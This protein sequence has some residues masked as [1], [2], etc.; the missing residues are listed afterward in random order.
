MSDQRYVVSI[1]FSRPKKWKPF[2]WLI[3]LVEKTKY[4]HTFVSWK[5]TN[6]NERKVFEAVGSG[7]RIISNHRFK[8]KALVVEIYHFE[9]P[10]ETI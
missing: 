2:A 9:V 5:C 4:S 1:G 8:E 6:I 10:V 3:M 7:V